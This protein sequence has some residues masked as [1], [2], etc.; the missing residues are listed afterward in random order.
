[1]REGITLHQ[2]ELNAT[3]ETLRGAAFKWAAM[4]EQ[5]RTFENDP[6]RDYLPETKMPT[7]LQFEAVYEIT[8]QTEAGRRDRDGPFT[9]ATE[10]AWCRSMLKRWAVKKHM[11][12]H[13]WFQ[14]GA[15]REGTMDIHLGK[16]A[17]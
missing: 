12:T 1:M 10:S 3:A 17:Q 14:H 15:D 9:P 13:G 5:T 8:E 16:A 2:L 11:T 4:N 7:D 6:L